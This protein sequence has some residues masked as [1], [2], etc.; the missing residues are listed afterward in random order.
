VTPEVARILG[1]LEARWQDFLSVI[2]CETD[3]FSFDKDIQKA[4]L[5]FLEEL[6]SVPEGSN[7]IW[8]RRDQAVADWIESLTK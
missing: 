1:A 2:E 5:L 6:R 3:A 7:A 8:I 4:L